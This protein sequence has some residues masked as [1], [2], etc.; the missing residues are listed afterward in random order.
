MS[1][2]TMPNRDEVPAASRSML[3]VVEERF[4]FVPNLFLLTASSPATLSAITGLAASL[5]SALDVQT[6]QRIALAVSQV[7]TCRYCLASHTARGADLEL[8][9]EEIARNR[10]GHSDDPVAD[11]AVHFATRVG[12]E[13]GHVTDEDLEEVRRAGFDDAQILE[14]I[15]VAVQYMFTNFINNVALTILDFPEVETAQP[16]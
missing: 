12:E 1:R 14:I 9:D 16:V 4:G 15:A 3:D 13:R 2:I 5:Q 10:A 7:D 8:S 6:R 11:A